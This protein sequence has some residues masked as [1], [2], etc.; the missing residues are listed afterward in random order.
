M[1][2]INHVQ[3]AANEVYAKLDNPLSATAQL[4]NTQVNPAAETNSVS[5]IEGVVSQSQKSLV[6]PLDAP[7]ALINISEQGRKLLASEQAETALLQASINQDDLEKKY[8]YR[9]GID[10]FVYNAQRYSQQDVAPP[11]IENR[12]AIEAYSLVQQK[13]VA[14]VASNPL[15]E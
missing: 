2:I 10:Q 12:A 4:A 14:T 13:V 7:S 8:K 11:L 5:A 1:Q 15:E 6:Q 3:S 9:L